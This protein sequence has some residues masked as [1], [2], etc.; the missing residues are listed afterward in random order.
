MELDL[1]P[2]VSQHFRK[3]QLDAQ[4]GFGAR[5]PITPRRT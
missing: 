2:R 3:V 1:K 4:K 5:E